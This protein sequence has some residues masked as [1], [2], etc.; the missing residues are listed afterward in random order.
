ME[1]TQHTKARISRVPAAGAKAA[2]KPKSAAA[3]EQPEQTIL[4]EIENVL[5]AM[6]R[7]DFEARARV[8]GTPG[9][10]AAFAAF[11]RVMD[12]GVGRLLW[13]EQI[14]DTVPLPLSVTDNEMRWT[15]IN[16]AVEKLLGVRRQDVIGNQCSKW[17]AT[18]CN[19]DKCGIARLRANQ[20]VTVFNQSNR[21]FRVDSAYLTDSTGNRI[22]HVEVITDT[23]AI[24]R[25]AAYQRT[26]IERLDG[27]LARLAE[28][29][30][31]FD[32]VAGAADEHTLACKEQFDRI[33][34][35]L[36]KVREVVE[37]LTKD[38]EML[39][40]AAAHGQLDTRA[41]AER[42]G[43][44]FRRIIEG[45]NHALDSVVGNLGAI[46]HPLQ[47]MDSDMRIQYIN[48]T[49]AKLLG[50]SK[51]Q[52]M[53]ARCSDLWK[54]SKCNT[55]ECPCETAA[56]ENR[57]VTCEND[58]LIAGKKYDIFC[59]GAPLHDENGKV[60]GSFEF[61]TDQ[62]E[63]KRAARLAE[64]VTQYRL[65]ETDRVIANLDKLAA[66]DLSIQTEVAPSDEDTHTAAEA[67]HQINESLNA[68]VNAIR[69]L[70][71]ETHML[72]EIVVGGNLSE[73]ADAGKH[74]GEYRNVIEGIN[75]VLDANLRP[76]VEVTGVIK[77]I[78]DR[79][80][81]ARIT[82]KYSGDFERLMEDINTM[83]EDLQSSIA[84]ITQH[85]AGL[86]SSSEELAAIS[87]QMAG[88][89]EE[90]ATQAS[91]VS[92]A[93][94]QVSR[95]VTVVSTGA[96]EMQ[97]SIR[98]IAKNSTESARVARQAVGVAETTNETI[99]KLGES[100]VEIGKVIKVI[101]SIAQQTNLLALNA[102]I[103]AARAGEAGKGFAVVANE[104]KELAKETAKATED[105]GQ[106]IEAIQNDTKRSVGAIGE[107]SSIINQIND[108]SN[109]IATAVEEQTVTTNEIGRNVGEAAKGTGE[110]AR[111]IAGVAQAA[112]TTTG[113]ASDTQKAAKVLSEMAA[114]LQVVVGKF[115]V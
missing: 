10:Q 63:L 92:A 58:T 11:N 8:Q 105:I 21:D 72:A 75:G 114:E 19:T 51:H 69:N 76:M 87:Q 80:L 60:I 23:T 100:S 37:A 93:S 103:E 5:A 74:K 47:F 81:T 26:E 6:E 45:I 27:N 98:E 20:P 62:S 110:I 85:T 34:T 66:G 29:K 112:Q 79:D 35:S 109:N 22:G 115:K 111:N 61:V 41:G 7:G 15:F 40:K 77:R 48:E 107:I 46:P 108:L 64:K 2:R 55:S 83:A 24:T 106:K 94:E 90:T 113:A 36:A 91:V 1:T 65:A 25:N 52:L 42:H 13:L 70:T 28:G 32:L 96:E 68:T 97:S 95:N 4:K 88:T 3:N 12:T 39:A 59:A 57:A 67:F 14:L 17:N 30:L 89:A 84:Q 38:A 43:G 104:V 50:R 86:A 53:G 99:G 33:N 49:G 102:T 16:K 44:V 101:T 71:R 9:T 78:A 18:I 31:E 73:R 54:T 82:G 56:R